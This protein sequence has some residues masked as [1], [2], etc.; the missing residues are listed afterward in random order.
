MLCPTCKSE[1]L[2][3][4]AESFREWCDSCGTVS[5]Q[6]DPSKTYVPT[7]YADMVEALAGIIGH[8]D[9]G[10]E[11]REAGGMIVSCNPA[12]ED[13]A[14]EISVTFSRDEWNA[15]KLLAANAAGLLVRK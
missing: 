13:N 7:I 2:N 5:D 3:I 8:D 1:M 4:D 15:L 10:F 12:D 14:E 6:H 9:V 11:W